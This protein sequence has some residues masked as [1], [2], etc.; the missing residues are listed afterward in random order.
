MKHTKTVCNSCGTT[1][2]MLGRCLRCNKICTTKEITCTPNEE[3][4]EVLRG[5]LFTDA[6][7]KE[8]EFDSSYHNAI[9]R[10]IA[11]QLNIKLWKQLTGSP[12]L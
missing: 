12:L 2:Y 11:E 10:S 7:S 4:A 3:I 1:E 8:A 6:E 9:I 5:K